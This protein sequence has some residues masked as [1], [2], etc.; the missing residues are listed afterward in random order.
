MHAG[1]ASV[2]RGALLTGLYFAGAVIAVLYLRTPADVTLF[3]PAAGIGY[4]VVLRYGL[5]F[6]PTIALAQL[7]LHLLLVPVPTTFLLFSVAS[8]SVATVLAC[9]YVQH[10]RTRLLF[11]IDD[12]LLLLRGGLLLSCISAAIGTMGMLQAG[13]APA[14]DLP[15][16]ALQWFLGDLL[17]ITAVT[18]SL[19][20]LSNLGH[21]ADAQAMPPEGGRRERA[22]WALLMLLAMTGA[23]LIGRQG[24]LYPLAMAS[25]PLALLL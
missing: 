17:G 24:S 2:L 11:R 14:T 23:F 25:L 15:R 10:R 5:K 3:W 21:R 7:L 8:N 20:F 9:A 18:P 13:M 19:L 1:M 12:G 6:A 22:V 4:A 16:V